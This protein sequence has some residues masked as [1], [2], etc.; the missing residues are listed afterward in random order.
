[1][2]KYILSAVLMLGTMFAQQPPLY[3][4]TYTGTNPLGTLT[5]PFTATTPYN[6]VI[7]VPPSGNYMTILT[8][9]NWK[10]KNITAAQ[11]AVSNLTSSGGDNDH[12]GSLNGTYL[13]AHVE[14]ANCMI[15]VTTNAKGQ[16]QNTTNGGE[17][18]C[19]QVPGQFG[20]SSVSDNVFYWLSESH[21][22]HQGTV[23]SDCTYVETKN[24]QFPFDYDTC[25]GT[26]ITPGT[27]GTSASI[28]GIGF[29]D[30]TFSVDLSWSGGQGTAHFALAY[31][32]GVGCS[33]LN[34]ATGQW[35]AYGASVVTGTE[36]GCL[37]PNAAAGQGMHD[38]QLTGDGGVL[39]ISGGAWNFGG[40][41]FCFWQAGTSN[42]VGMP[43]VGNGAAG[44]ESATG[45]FMI[46]ADNP[47]PNIRLV[48][49]LSATNVTTGFTVLNRLPL[50]PAGPGGYHGAQPH[51]LGTDLT[52]WIVESAGD[53]NGVSYLTPEY[54]QNEIFGIPAYG[55]DLPILR[56]G[57]MYN[58]GT[59]G[60]FSCKYGIGYPIPNGSGWSTLT[61][62]LG[63]F[64][65]TAPCRWAVLKIVKP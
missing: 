43:A 3:T 54:L 53:G 64:G 27:N 42:A 50:S 52:P 29:D 49:P 13:W 35:Y 36:S 25:P 20:T 59:T 6:T 39:I 65:G 37:T 2:F 62:G 34:T 10:C 19:I 18:S 57:T 48:S 63:S 45:H 12:M 60:T 38:Q 46:N 61:D 40:D 4:G 9:Q 15:H 47:T 22:L 28:I 56:F 8:D 5:P 14:G 21:L 11:L 55:Y 17:N 7:Q 51:P 30:Q 16:F 33:T 44:H 58:S 31:K 32:P 26:G 41:N 1:M 23:T 24:A